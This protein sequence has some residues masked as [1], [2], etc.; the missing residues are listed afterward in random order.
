MLSTFC[1]FPISVVSFAFIVDPRL[2]PWVPILPS[3]F[4]PFIV[5]FSLFITVCVYFAVVDFVFLSNFTSSFSLPNDVAVSPV[6][7]F[8]T[9]FNAISPTGATIFTGATVVPPF[10]IFIAFWLL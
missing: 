8:V 2:S 1:A 4:I 10:S 5:S 7:S 3:I 9:V 6:V